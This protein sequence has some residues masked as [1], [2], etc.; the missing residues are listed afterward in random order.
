[1]GWPRWTAA[2]PR[3]SGR[4]QPGAQA[5]MNWA[6]YDFGQ[7]ARN[8]G[9]YN[10]R[11][12][13]SGSR[14]IHGDGRAIDVGFS[15]V[16]N[17]AGTRLLN[18]LLPHVGALGIQ[19]IIWNKKVYS[20]RYPRGARYTGVSPHTDHLHIELTWN[21]A[22]TLTR[23]RVQQVVRGAGT[24]QAGSPIDWKAVRRYGASVLLPQVQSLP[25]LDGSSSNKQQVKTLQKAL[26][27]VSN[28][29][30]KEDGQ[31]GPATINA[32][33]NFQKF[34]NH[35]GGN[36]KDFPGAAHEGTRWWLSMSL[37]NIK[38]GKA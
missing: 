1:M 26:N 27:F 33:L 15:G 18:T 36:I 38:K 19:M 28:A 2:S 7:G 34:M 25:N 12:T 13:G 6:L 31:Y 8:L 9:I 35:L 20:A 17:P 24:P 16:G 3:C 14:S 32:V 30:L 37:M 10:C 5:L 21:A 29:G 4:I 11:G 22:S 23:T